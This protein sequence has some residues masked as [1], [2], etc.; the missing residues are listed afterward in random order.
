MNIIWPFGILQ[1]QNTWLP[2]GYM[3]YTNNL[4][5]ALE[6]ITA[7]SQTYLLK[8]SI[9]LL[10]SKH[11]SQWINDI[12]SWS[13]L[14]DDYISLANK[15]S[16]NIILPFYVFGFLVRPRFLC[17]SNGSIAVTKRGISDTTEGTT[18]CREA[19]NLIQIASL[20][21]SNAA[22]YSSRL[23]F[24]KRALI[25]YKSRLKHIKKVSKS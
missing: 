8:M 22:K 16:D 6:T 24:S 2:L 19:N 11:S 9:Q 20:A 15:L 3:T 25:S 4:P 13:Y 10:L 5:F 7:V 21:A 12:I 17:Q 1:C 18:P 23:V 14:L